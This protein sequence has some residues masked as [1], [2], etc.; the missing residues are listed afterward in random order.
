MKKNHLDYVLVLAGVLLLGTG[1]LLIRRL[2]HP[3]HIMR[4]LPYV[5]I[6]VGCGTFGHGMG[7][8]ISRRALKN[9]PEAARQLEIDRRDER[10]IAIETRAK[11]KAYDLMTYVFGAVMV[12][13]ALMGVEL[14][15]VLILVFAY[16]LVHGW[17]IYYRCKYEQEM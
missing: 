2:D 10:N 14:T 8:L 15:A 9:A 6:G 1:V 7:E 12:S 13:F 11:A 17:G 5:C 16:L 4:A 3:E